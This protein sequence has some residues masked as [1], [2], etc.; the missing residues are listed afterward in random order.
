MADERILDVIHEIRGEN[1]EHAVL[2]TLLHEGDTFIDVGAN[3]GTFSLLASSIVGPSGMVVA[4]EPQGRLCD[5]I[6]R[7][8]DLSDVTNCELICAGCGASATTLSLMVPYNDSGRAGFFSDFSGR[9]VHESVTAEVMTL[10][11]ALPRDTPGHMVIK[12]DVEGSEAAVLDGARE[13]IHLKNPSLIIEMNPWSAKAAGTSTTALVQK[14]I[15]FGY[16]HFSIAGN[17]LTSVEPAA[18]PHDRQLNLVAT[19]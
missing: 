15:E 19:R 13:T 3:F 4:F 12:I 11:A 18:I 1:P 6:R 8:L 9:Y 16:V 7:S 10:D 17:G 2:S 14:L 5:L